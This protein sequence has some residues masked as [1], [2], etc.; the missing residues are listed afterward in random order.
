M[1]RSV[2]V[3]LDGSLLAAR[4]LPYAALVAAPDARIT[5]IAVVAERYLTQV[6]ER[7]KPLVVRRDWLSSRA[8]PPAAVIGTY[9]RR[10]PPG[11]VVMASH[12]RGGIARWV[13]GSTTERVMTGASSPV[14]VVRAPTGP[15]PPNPLRFCNRAAAPVTRLP[16]GTPHPIL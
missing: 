14:L 6:A 4:A 2:I 1:F 10:Q 9:L 7:L 3:P 13:L 8:G 16:R 15:V 12:G 5:L 11:I